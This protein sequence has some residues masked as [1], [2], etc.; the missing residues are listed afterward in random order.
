MPPDR[1][2]YAIGVS[3]DGQWALSRT[4]NAMELDRW[5][6]AADHGVQNVGSGLLIASHEN[7]IYGTSISS[8]G[9][10]LLTGSADG[11]VRLWD[12]GTGHLLRTFSRHYPNLKGGNIVWDVAFSPDGNFGAS[13][14]SDGRVELWDFSE[15]SDVYLESQ[16][17]SA[18]AAT[19]RN[20]PVDAVATTVLSGWYASR[21]QAKWA[22]ETLALDRVRFKRITSTLSA[23]E[24]N[25]APLEGSIVEMDRSIFTRLPLGRRLNFYLNHLDAPKGKVVLGA[26]P[27][28][29]PREGNNAFLTAGRDNPTAR[30]PFKSL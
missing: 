19:L 2:D 28:D 11:L 5:N 13:S 4:S 3:P 20:N 25:D 14:P 16:G 6:L 23:P 30:P 1:L 18:A 12:A 26:V 15:K 27:F 7:I 10:R 8:N 17:A 21:G 22:S 29:I 24:N 9:T